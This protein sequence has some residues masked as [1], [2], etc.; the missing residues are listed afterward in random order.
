MTGSRS[1]PE[2]ASFRRHVVYAGQ[3]SALVVAYVAPGEFG[4]SI[5]PVSHYAPLVWPPTGLALAAL[6]LGGYRLWPG[7]ALGAFVTNF[8]ADAPPV[9]ASGMAVGNTLEA[10]AGTFFLR[11]IPGFRSSFD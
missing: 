6:V 10:V 8:L 1:M 4:L 5:A 7:I 11:C 3:L 9:V 2:K